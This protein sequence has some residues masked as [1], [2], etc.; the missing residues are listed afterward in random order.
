MSAHRFFV[1]P[2]AVNGVTAVITDDDA[3]QIVQVLRL[4]PGETICVL[5]NTGAER[6][7]VIEQ[8]SANRVTVRCVDT[9]YPDTEPNTRVWVY[10]ALAKGDRVETALQLATQAG[11][12]G[13]GVF[14]AARCVVRLTDKDAER[15]AVRWRRVIKEAAE[16]SH[17]AR[18]PGWLGFGTL[19]RQIAQASGIRV[20][21]HPDPSAP[22]LTALRA[23]APVNAE[24]SLFVG[25]EG[26]FTDQEVSQAVAAGARVA[27]LMPR[28]LRTEAAA[29][30]AVVQ[31]VTESTTR[32]SPEL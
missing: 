16:Q 21:L 6:M 8:A 31:L 27:T 4:G 22:S 12:A 26:G 29:F 3:R 15:K 32:T 20:L 10:Q 14:D 19:E 1:P 9:V 11:A 30:A 18:L 28:I 17:R 7:C 24:W 13:F 25:P 2:D 5:D 23:S